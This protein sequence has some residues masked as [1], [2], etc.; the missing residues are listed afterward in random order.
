MPMISLSLPHKG[1][2]VEVLLVLPRVLQVDEGRGEG[3][4]QPVRGLLVG[5]V[6]IQVLGVLP[7]VCGVRLHAVVQRRAVQ[8][9][10]AVL[11]RGLRAT[12]EREDK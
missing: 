4:V 8:V 11:Q 7:V 9:V 1:Q 6:L 3:E 12:R 2:V 5:Q 10:A